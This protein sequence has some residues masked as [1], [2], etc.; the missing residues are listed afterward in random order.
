MPSLG[1]GL[2]LGTIN[3]ISGYDFDASTYIK[4]NVISDNIINVDSFSTSKNSLLVGK[5]AS[6][7]GQVSAPHSSSLNLNSKSWS[8]AGWWIPHFATGTASMCMSKSDQ[9]DVREFQLQADLGAS[10]NL[11]FTFAIYP[12][13]TFANRK[14]MIFVLNGTSSLLQGEKYFIYFGYDY[15][16]QKSFVS[17]N[18][19]AVTYSS[20]S[21]TNTYA[22][23]NSLK[24]GHFVDGSSTLKALQS[25]DEFGFWNRVLTS[26][27]LAYLYNS[28]LGRSYSELD[29]SH[30][31]SLISWWSMDETSGNR[32]DSHGSNHITSVTNASCSIP[33]AGCFSYVNGQALVNNAILNLKNSGLWTNLIDGMLL[34]QGLNKSSGTPVSL[35][36]TLTSVQH[37]GANLTPYGLNC[38]RYA[39]ALGLTPATTSAFNSLTES[40][41][42]AVCRRYI[43]P[44]DYAFI[45]TAPSSEWEVNYASTGVVQGYL[46]NVACPTYTPS[47]PPF[48]ESS[49]VKIGMV[50]SQ[51]SSIF[52]LYYNGTMGTNT[53][54]TTLTTGNP[55][56]D[57]R[58][59]G[60]RSLTNGSSS[61]GFR[62]VVSQ[63]Y[64]FNKALSQAELN[65]ILVV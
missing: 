21:V 19:G 20:V 61:Y 1:T 22:G 7:L 42:F 18:G 5:N 54:N 25:Y 39:S 40:S 44:Q 23:S 9:A 53:A 49:Y 64:W 38:P 31:T 50:A 35:K 58:S 24:F 52:R 2:S 43:Y 6:N 36:N 34:K 59:I 65:S 46:S 28:S 47:E 3:R 27:E 15:S 10:S 63:I 13:G 48:V 26:T 11:Q 57:R 45:F 29:A 32:N 55:G 41:V 56:V 30:K 12:D 62:G 14:E 60:G 51:T 16:Q 33:L 8:F 4:N 37:T 17:V